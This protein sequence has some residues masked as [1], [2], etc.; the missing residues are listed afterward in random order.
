MVTHRATD[1][2]P[3]TGTDAVHSQVTA[4][5]AHADTGGG[6]VKPAT[7]TPGQ[8]LGITSN[9]LHATCFGGG[10]Q[11]LHNSIKAIESQAFLDKSVQRQIKRPRAADG[12]VV[13][14]TVDGQRT[15]V[16]TRKFKR[17]DDEAIGTHV[18]LT[19]ARQADGRCVQRD[20]Q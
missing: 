12:Q 6:Q 17:F 3:V 1:Q 15:D 9:Y 16:T 7:L 5:G 14:R 10:S 13:D 11:A 19:F 2:H 18:R 20:I 4:L 8:N